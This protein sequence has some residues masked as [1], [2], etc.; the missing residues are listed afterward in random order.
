MIFPNKN[1]LKYKATIMRRKYYRKPRYE[2]LPARIVT[3]STLP[4]RSA[5]LN[6]LYIEAAS[7]NGHQKPGLRFFVKII[8]SWYSKSASADETTLE[9]PTYL[10]RSLN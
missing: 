6:A 4:F 2:R 9:K 3:T 1:N 7:S 8:D 5:E 10:R